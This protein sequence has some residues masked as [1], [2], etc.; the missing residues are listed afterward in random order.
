MARRRSN[1]NTPPLVNPASEWIT[2]EDYVVNGRH[3]TPGT[4]FKVSNE[5]GRFLF[6]RH[7]VNG[8]K[9]WIDAKSP[10]GQFR[11]FRVERVK[12]VHIKKHIR[13]NTKED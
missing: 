8:D 4:E 10:E 6:L 9:E 7:V 13:G 12:T 11:A 1:P 5:R 3:L 2:T